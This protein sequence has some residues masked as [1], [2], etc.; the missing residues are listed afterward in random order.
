MLKLLTPWILAGNHE[1]NFIATV[2]GSKITKNI[3]TQIQFHFFL[4]LWLPS[5]PSFN[6][7][8]CLDCCFWTR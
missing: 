4:S 6:R 2:Q 5:Y 7:T 3:Y 1:L 8:T